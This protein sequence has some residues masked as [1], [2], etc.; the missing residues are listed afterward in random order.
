VGEALG[1]AGG[2]VA[3]HG[4]V[5]AR[6]VERVLQLHGS[7]GGIGKVGAGERARRGIAA[8]ANGTRQRGR[9]L[10]F[11]AGESSKVGAE[12]HL[13]WRRRVW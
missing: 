5:G 6:E 1:L 9:R 7:A 8:G 13:P 3:P 10:A 11:S 4:E 12:E 2:E